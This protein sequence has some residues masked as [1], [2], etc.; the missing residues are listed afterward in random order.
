MFGTPVENVA[1]RDLGVGGV[2]SWYENSS[3][4][5][6]ETQSPETQSSEPEVLVQIEDT[7][8]SQPILLVTFLFAAI[9]AIAIAVKSSKKRNKNEQ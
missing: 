1:N 3:T 9:V 7:E 5:A 8:N 6:A 4:L 2:M